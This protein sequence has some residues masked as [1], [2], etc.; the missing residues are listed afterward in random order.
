MVG[1]SWYEAKAFARWAGKDLPSSDQWRFAAVAGTRSAFPWGD[2]VQSLPERA[3]FGQVGTQPV[4]SYPLGVSPFGCY[5]MAGNVK[6]WLRDR[7]GNGVTCAIVG[8]SWRDES[9]MFEAAHA[10]SFEPSFATRDV[11]FRC[12]KVLTDDKSRGSP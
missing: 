3:N 7:S 2:E 12:V 5:D 1:V 11:G 4:G 10:E 9:Y 8:G 6:E